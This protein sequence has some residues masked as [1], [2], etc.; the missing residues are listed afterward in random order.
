MNIKIEV[1]YQ[2]SGNVCYYPGDFQQ[3]YSILTF[4]ELTT[5]IRENLA[6]HNFNQAIAFDLRGHTVMVITRSE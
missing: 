4:D 5:M 6:E 3:S 1:P 2:I